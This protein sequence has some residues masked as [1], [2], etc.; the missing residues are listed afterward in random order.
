MASMQVERDPVVAA[1]TAGDRSAFTLLFNRHRR[2]LHAH[3]YRMLG[4][5]ED[6]EDLTQETFLRSWAS[7]E[8]FQ[9]RSSFRAWL[10]RIATNASLS[11][12][13]RRQVRR[14]IAQP[15]DERLLEEVAAPDP[16]PDDAVV[17]G[18]GVELALLTALRH[19]PPMQRAVLFLR[20]LHG[21]SAKDTAE[22]L[23]TSVASV[24]SALYRA[25]ATMRLEWERGDG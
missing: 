2:E 25:R 23:E 22:L 14:R 19:L 18:E 8:T 17:A 10:Y 11:A 4:S 13:E 1:A 3:A 7:R 12:L 21:W 5:H 9:G 16:P 15:A 24:N 20:D 6:A